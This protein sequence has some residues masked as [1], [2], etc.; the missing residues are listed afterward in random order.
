MRNDAS[1]EDDGNEVDAEQLLAAL[2]GNIPIETTPKKQSK[3]VTLLLVRLSLAGITDNEDVEDTRFLD[4]FRKC[5]THFKL[6]LSSL[7]R[8]SKLKQ[9]IKMLGQI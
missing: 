5:L 9:L 7:L 8:V 4:E 1:E 2:S 6:P 3:K